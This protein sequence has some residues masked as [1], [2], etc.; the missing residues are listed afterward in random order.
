MSFAQQ[1]ASASPATIHQSTAPVELKISEAH[2]LRYQKSGTGPA[3][4]LLHTIRT[5]LEYFRDLVPL[6]EESFTVYTVDLPGHG[7]SR[8]DPKGRYDET[9]FREGVVGFIEKLDLADVTI[10]GESIGGVLALTVATAIPDRIRQV[11]SINPY[12]YDT[13]Y[14][15]GIRRGNAFA[16]LIVGSLQIP[17]IGAIFAAIENKFVLKNI[18]SGGY[19]DPRKFP[20]DLLNTLNAVGSRPGIRKASRKVLSGWRSWSA[21]RD[22]YSK[23][24][25][26]VTLIY[27]DSDWSRP[28]E[29]ERTR[30]LIPNARS[31]VLKETG[32]FS[33]VE[34][35][36]DLARAMLQQ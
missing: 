1:N 5:Q 6:L 11:I 27:G 30:N 25:V 17:V 16:N 12:D 22:R 10:A 15:D 26:P 20:D 4:V 35:P 3:L 36:K 18:M 14:G 21:A 28:A 19:H 13:R 33:A 31:I 29:R 23:L 8:I 2:T 24:D 9:Y 7:Y 34:S 32:H